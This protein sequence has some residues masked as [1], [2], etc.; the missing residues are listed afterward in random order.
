MFQTN[1]FFSTP[2]QFQSIQPAS[3]TQLNK[4][5]KE[6]HDDN[7]YELNIPHITVKKKKAKNAFKEVI[8]LN[9]QLLL[10]ILLQSYL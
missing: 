3:N 7:G 5:Y 4:A 1:D 9:C 10:Q 8:Y 2:P 6:Q